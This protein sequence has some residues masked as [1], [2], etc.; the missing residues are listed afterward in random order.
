MDPSPCPFLHCFADP[1]GFVGVSWSIFGLHDQGWAERQ[2]FGKIRFMNFNGCKRKF[3]VD[4]FIGKYRGAAK[5]ALD[6]ERKHKPTS[7]KAEAPP[8]KKRKTPA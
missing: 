3:K 1:N 5:N 6:A 7:N 2:V 4:T 8:A